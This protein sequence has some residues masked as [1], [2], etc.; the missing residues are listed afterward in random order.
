MPRIKDDFKPKLIENW[1]KVEQKHIL[2]EL[3]LN[4]NII[5][6]NNLELDGIWTK[7]EWFELN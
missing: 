3:K 6:T 2:I 5:W 7:I 4:L 1:A